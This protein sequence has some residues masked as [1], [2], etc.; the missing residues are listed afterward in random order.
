MMEI[1][2]SLSPA[3]QADLQQGTFTDAS[4]RE[5]LED[6]GLV[7]ENKITITL[8][9]AFIH[10]AFG[11]TQKSEEK[12][13]Y[14]QNTNTIC[15]GAVV[16]S[17]QLTASEFRVLRY[18]LQNQERVVERDEIVSVVWQNMKSTAGITDQ[19]IDQLIFR[20]R[21]KIEEDPNNPIHLQTVKGRGFRFIA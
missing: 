18:L 21:R 3:E 13:I 2:L 12:I 19:A 6:V 20:V 7:K 14:D 1:W 8:F 5:Y 10:S 9:A 15:K 11:T 4:V 17:D 16:L